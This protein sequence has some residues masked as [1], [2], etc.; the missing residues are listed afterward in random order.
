VNRL[1]FYPLPGFRALCFVL[2]LLC[3]SFDGIAQDCPDITNPTPGSSNVPVTTSI[4]WNAVPGVTGY[5]ISLG[6]TPGGGEIV[7]EQPV[8]NDPNFTPPLGLP[9]NTQIHVTIIL[10]F[11]DQP[12][13]V[14]PSQS[15]STALV[16]QAPGCAMLSTPMDGDTDVIVSTDLFWDYVP[17]AT[18]YRLS[19]GTSPGG[20]ELLDNVDLGNVLSYSPAADFP[21][22]TTIYVR[23]QPYNAV[24]FAIDCLEE[25]FTTG[26]LGDPP[27]CTQMISPGDGAINVPLTPLI[28]WAPAPGAIG[29]R[30]Y[31]GSTPFE[32]DVVDGIVITDTSTLVLDFDP[33]QTY[34]IRIVPFNKAGEAQGCPQETFSTLLGC[35]P[36]IDPDTAELIVLNPEIGLPD[37][38]GICDGQLPTRYQSPDVADGYRWFF[39]TPTGAEVLISEER[40]VDL[41]ETGNYR[42][43]VYN[44]TEGEGDPIEC[45][46]E[47]P[48]EVIL[49]G[50]AAIDFIR[51]EENA[52]FFYIEIEV[53]GAGQYEYA[54]DDIEGPY[55]DSNEFGG[56]SE[57]YYTVYVRDKGG[58][59]IA[60]EEFRLA[61]PPTG[62]PPYFSPNG[63][64]INDTW[65]Y[66]PPRVNPLQI[67]SIYIFDRF[68]K[69]LFNFGTTSQGWD[70]KYNN[71][72]MPSGGYWYR[73]LTRDGEEYRGNFSLV[74]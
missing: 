12:D 11:F 70:G 31:I 20:S 2:L 7:N 22:G 10:F 5:I 39:V 73:A 53:S 4:S 55:Q 57:G 27:G 51:K 68:G 24:G 17:L 29:Y 13:I 67:R 9:S 8:G 15:F 19:M 32:N 74:R 49:S 47:K 25:S 38:I 50:I 41:E 63:D 58:C 62:F 65:Q 35:G 45:I 1:F 44:L 37:Q 43:E 6:T 64:G 30:L 18:G 59:G 60:Q 46:S 69:L 40:F 21:P 36:Y 52:T 28:E 72:D 71:N 34:F 42:Y 23:L 16:T 48:F 3:L 26:E 14:C 56:L 54:L 33:N 61:Y 66:V